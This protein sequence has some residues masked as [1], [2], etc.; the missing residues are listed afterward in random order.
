MRAT[1]AR[2]LD[3]LGAD[4]TQ[5][6]IPVYQREY[7][8]DTP[9]LED[10]WNDV[11]LAGKDGMTHFIGSFL[12][13]PEEDS[14]ATSIHRK[15]LIDGQQRM[16]TLSLLL[17]AL[18]DFLDEDDSRAQ[19][20][21]DLSPKSLRKSYLFND[22]Y[23]GESRYK[24]VLSMDD[25][26]TMHTLVDGSQLPEHP[27]RR[28]VEAK[29]FFTNKI[30]S[31]NVSPKTLW[32][33]LN[34]LVIIDTELNPNE[35][36]AQLI[37]ESMNSKGK[38]L[39]PIDLV[40]NFILLS[41]PADR[42]KEL[43][44]QYWSHIEHLFGQDA[45]YEFNAFLWYWLYLKIP[46]R[47]P[48]QDNAY[49]DFKYY[50]QNHDLDREPETILSELLAYATR[51]ARLFLGQEPDPSLKR[52]F[53][54]INSLGVRPVRPL[55]MCLYT[56]MDE[57]KLTKDEFGSLCDT[58][59]SF[60]FRRMVVGKS[61]QGLN[62][63][64]AGMYRRL[65]DAAN[66]K[67]CLTAL[68]L[69]PEN[70][71]TGYFPDDGEFAEALTTRDIYNGLKKGKQ[72]LLE[73]L[74]NS[75]HP[76]EPINSGKYQIEHVMPQ[77]IDDSDAWKTML[78][79]D[80]QNIHDTLC[81]TLGNLTLTGYNQEY[82]NKSFPEKQ[83]LQPG[84]FK[85]SQL[86]LNLYIADRN[87]WNAEIIRQRAEKLADRACKIWPRPTLQENII[88]QYRPRPRTTSRS[89]SWTI[90]TSQ[91]ELAPGG[92]CH[93]LF[94]QLQQALR[95]AQ[96]DWT[97]GVKKNYVGYYSEYGKALHI[98]IKARP[99]L[100]R[101]AIGLNATVDDLDDPNGYAQDKR[102]CGGFEAG[103]LT[104]VDLRSAEDIPEVMRLINQC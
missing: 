58:I 65:D 102:P 38:P 19:F 97:L 8:W 50:V 45:E 33:G 39:T 94:E 9:Q 36:N 10:L 47:N 53:D 91:P 21:T 104:R 22:D 44:D 14:T 37:F 101:L 32:D 5:F 25:K 46:E 90:E 42:Q 54:R 75:Y 89:G 84:G 27:V 2:F 77:T 86:S 62:K 82:S 15:L 85:Y 76:K 69:A 23:R 60:L 66:P 98:V 18:L 100:T 40:R 31:R 80:W 92:K 24:L 28:L 96:P 12:Y 64:F 67:T 4:R 7:S 35:D 30:R 34:K 83:N 57:R 81:H 93:E 26:A 95:E 61:T 70:N 73:R 72:Y 68:L 16:T 87:V 52:R 88:D 11:T 55:L 63:M 3:L 79:P 49:H 74:E 17:A 43:Y 59:E 103:C 20:L 99:S 51:Y 48:K 1:Q 56:L 78:G 13:I 71:A 29:A 41:L 6:I